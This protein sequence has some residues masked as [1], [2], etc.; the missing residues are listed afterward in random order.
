MNDSWNLKLSYLNQIRW[1]I[2]IGYYYFYFFCFF[3]GVSKIFTSK[4]FTLEALIDWLCFGGRSFFVDPFYTWSSI[5]NELCSFVLKHF[6]K[7]S[8]VFVRNLYRY[9]WISFQK[10]GSFRLL[11]ESERELCLLIGISTLLHSCGVNVRTFQSHTSQLL[12]SCFVM[13]KAHAWVGEIHKMWAET[14]GLYPTLSHKVKSESFFL[15][16]SGW[17]GIC[18]IFLLKKVSTY[19]A[20]KA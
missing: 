2:V 15:W 17:F 18:E 11:R 5:A 6:E 7:C 20:T 3:G 16:L 13:S 12:S 4:I 8:S 10:G 14:K 9:L 19:H 1:I